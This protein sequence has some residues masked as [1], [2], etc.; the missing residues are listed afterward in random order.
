[1]DSKARP[2]WL[3]FENYNSFGDDIHLIFKNGDDLR[4][5]M[6]TLQMLRIMDNLWKMHG[7]DLRYLRRTIVELSSTSAITNY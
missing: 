6:L 4:Q 1:M 7:L 5:D 2:M 3:V